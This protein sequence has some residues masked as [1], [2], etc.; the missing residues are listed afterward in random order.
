MYSIEV[1]SKLS[2]AFWF[3]VSIYIYLTNKCFKIIVHE[4]I[5]IFLSQDLIIKSKLN[6]RSIVIIFNTYTF[7]SNHH[8]L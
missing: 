2:N 3:S 6:Y 5:Y 8:I 4:L 7:M 1:R